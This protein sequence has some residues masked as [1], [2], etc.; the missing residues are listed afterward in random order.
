MPVS[1]LRLAMKYRMVGT[2][3][4][5][6]AI[7]I[8]CMPMISGGNISYGRA[9]RDESIATIQESIDSGVNFF[10]TAEFY[11]PFNNEALLGEAIQGQT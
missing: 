8:G 2:E 5:V 3:L 6:S 9:D 7:G 4:R 10:D 11:G 1:I